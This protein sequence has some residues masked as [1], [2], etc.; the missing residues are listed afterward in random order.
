MQLSVIAVIPKWASHKSLLA[1]STVNKL[2]QS[3]SELVKL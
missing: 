2:M 3:A 1:L